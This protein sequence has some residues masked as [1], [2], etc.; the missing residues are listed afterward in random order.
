VARLWLFLAYAVFVVYGSLVP[1]DFRPQPLDVA[2]QHFQHIPWLD[3]GLGG[4]AD[5][6]ANAVLYAP[7]AF[8]TARAAFGLGLAQALACALAIALCSALAVGVEFTQ[9]FFPPRT[10]SLND[11]LAE[12]LGSLVGALSAPFAAGWLDRLAEA[13]ARR[14]GHLGLRLLEMYAVAY[15]AL[16]FFPYDLLLSAT[17]IHIKWQSTLWGWWLAPSARGGAITAVQLL[18]EVVL[19]L[20]IGLLL[21]RRRAGGQ[22]RTPIAAVLGLVLGL[23]IEVGQFF[24]DSGVSQGASVLTRALGVAAGAWLAPGALAA[25]PAAVRSLLRRLALPAWLIY[26]PVLLEVNG[27]FSHRWQGSAAAAP[28]WAEV[29][30]LPFYYHYYTTEAIALFSLGSVALMYLPAALLGW[31]RVWPQR[32]TLTGVAALASAIEASKLFMVGLHPDP[33]NVLIAVGAGAAVLELV[34]L[35]DRRASPVAAPSLL[36][37]GPPA[38]AAPRLG[39]VW[40]LVLPAAAA[41]ALL[42][43]AF[44]LALFALLV[45]SAAAVWRWPLLALALLPAALPALDLAPWSGRFYWDEFDLLSAVCLAVAWHRT[46]GAPR[47]PQV[48]RLLTWAF[49]L[50]GLS[51]LASTL[52]VLWP[53]PPLDDNS[54]SSYYSAWNALRI[55]K[56][57]AWA[58]L[59]VLLWRRLESHGPARA[60][61]FTRGMVAGL[62]L[63]VLVVLWER[64]TFV[65][66]WDFAADFRVTGPIS[67]MHKGGAF[68]ECWLAVAAAF[69]LGW[70]FEARKWPQGIAAAWLLAGAG[71]SMMV[72]YSRNG[73]AAFGVVVV[74]ALLALLVPGWQ[75]RAWRQAAW[76]GAMLA[77]VL[78]VTVPIAFAPYAHSRLSR[79]GQDLATRQVHWLDGLRLRDD[80][81][82]TAVFGMGL[83]RFPETHY[84]RSQ[85]PVH[86]ATYRLGREGARRFLSLGMGATLFVE[87][88]VPRPAPGPLKL[89]LQLRAR[90]GPAALS[91][92]LCEKWLLTSLRCVAATARTTLEPHP[93][94]T[95]WQRVEVVLDATQLLEGNS[96]W[97]APL[98]LALLTPGSGTVDVTDLQLTS[99]AG[100]ELLANG[101]FAQNMDHWFFATDADPPWQLHSLPL[102]VLFDQGWLG[103]VAW[104]A[105]LLCALGAGLKL[106]AQGRAQVPM[107][108]AA[109]CGFFV[110]GSLNTLI[111]NPRFLGL[112][113]VLL[114]LAAAPGR[115]RAVGRPDGAA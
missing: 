26:L 108:L 79:V 21:A 15:V 38:P 87:Q 68:I 77:L 36:E 111:D 86:A 62:A 97:R 23:C 11:I 75:R 48:Q 25:T 57:A 100:D 92:S 49:A 72:T 91:V 1:L 13:L 110:S 33:T 115:P 24:V 101:S 67:A 66:L 54:F 84:W 74:V 30:F 42:F 88:I 51:L 102:T 73:Y 93:A 104:T 113:L 40:L 35:L 105:V 85:E 114:W 34:A 46:Q 44:P 3:I 63:T 6:V 59:F 41:W 76:G 12:V 39:S 83:G 29:H 17:E 47:A 22:L 107:A 109:A 43:P 106:A 90:P 65:G 2:L 7:L 96:V 89:S 55:A 94:K 53:L 81:A 10:V 45:A 20:P 50:L 58:W 18:V 52:R 60:R 27:L 112:L 37:P 80:S 103:V 32:A 8:L 16:C 64:A 61:L 71:Y 14:S 69:A 5:W 99:A 98:T 70:A 78:A 19:A 4:R 95:S 56:G 31:A 82:L 28:A 9:L